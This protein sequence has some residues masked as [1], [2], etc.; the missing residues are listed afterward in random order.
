MAAN[1]PR[2]LQAILG[3]ARAPRAL[4]REDRVRLLGECFEALRDGRTPSR[5]AALFVAGG[6]LAWLEGRGDLLRECWRVVRPK[7]HNT[8]AAI[9]R[10]LRDSSSG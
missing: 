8:A 7:S 6:G 9:W 1:D 2:E 4:T 3:G 5:E 10:R